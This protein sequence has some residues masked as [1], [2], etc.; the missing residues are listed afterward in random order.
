MRGRRWSR[1][2]GLVLL[3]FLTITLAGCSAD[4]GA[5]PPAV[6]GPDCVHPA[7]LGA[8]A[9]L[10]AQAQAEVAAKQSALAE[11]LYTTALSG[12]SSSDPVRIC[13]AQGLSALAAGAAVTPTPAQDTASSWDSFYADWI[14]PAVRFLV[15]MLVVLAILL[16]VVR[17]VTGWVVSVGEPGPPKAG[18]AST[19]TTNALYWTGFALLVLAAIEVVAALPLARDVA[20]ARHA[21]WVQILALPIAVPLGIAV[22]LVAFVAIG[23]RLADGSRR[24]ILL[25]ALAAVLVLAGGLTAAMIIGRG[26]WQTRPSIVVAS[27]MLIVLGVLAMARVRGLQLGLVIQG[28]D[29][30]GSDN[31]GLA[32]FVRSRLVE[33]GARPPQGIQ[34][35]QNTDVTTLSEQALTL[36]PDGPVA[37]AVAVLV[38]VVL[39]ANPWKALVTDQED[40]GVN[41]VLTRN[42]KVAHS[43]VIRTPSLHL[44]DAVAAGQKDGPLADPTKV[45]T[46][47][48]VA[49][50][51]FTLVALSERYAHLQT[52]LS[53]ATNWRSVA[54]QVIAMDPSAGWSPDQT[55]ILLDAACDFDAGNLAAKT[56]RAL[57]YLGDDQSATA[58]TKFVRVLEGVL[59]RLT[60]TGVEVSA[61]SWRV[62]VNL[63]IGRL[64]YT[65]TLLYSP[66][67][68]AGAVR[69][70]VAAREQLTRLSADM[71]S[72]A[73]S[74]DLDDLTRQLGPIVHWLLVTIDAERLR[75]EEPTPVLVSPAPLPA[76]VIQMDMTAIYQKAGAYVTCALAV[77]MPT[78]D[79]PEVGKHAQEMWDQAFAAMERF[80]VIPGLRSWAQ[81]D[82]AFG[83]LHDVD[84]VDASVVARFKK[85]VGD[86]VPNDLASLAPFAD[87]GSQLKARGI[88]AFDDV[89]S[90]P[91]GWFRDELS[92]SYAQAVQWRAT[93]ALYAVVRQS[94]GGDDARA[95]DWMY[96][97]GRVGVPDVGRLQHELAAQPGRT[98]LRARMIAA[99][100]S[101]A[102]VAPSSS[103]LDRLATTARL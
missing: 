45:A 99:A 71:A 90:L 59:A 73:R 36:V 44:R 4:H 16:V 21:P 20:T 17:V 103:D 28:S 3:V 97:L 46:Q 35:T 58:I 93:L 30:K 84:L 6:A 88:T 86:P 51:A 100:R 57:Q 65:S 64:N 60:A 19:I 70:L 2:G 48:H 78:Q 43:T 15:P 38:A 83:C 34:A 55:Q 26:W 77:G 22:V 76:T 9:A 50:A 23:G 98:A 37:K 95:R 7:S 92:L 18:R 41:V 75:R 101:A 74:D 67:N 85:M 25:S 33:L 14:S 47:L 27:A 62:R 52:G 72:S 32:A 1:L 96:L 63:A 82:P 94:I 79:E 12:A 80:S 24:E 56:N 89:L 5:A 49:A 68:Q 102:I 31:A 42:G 11:V 29:A 91:L 10:I 8:G 54:L 69:E 39:P 13:A 61:L 81:A 87:C 53:G 66:E 40:G